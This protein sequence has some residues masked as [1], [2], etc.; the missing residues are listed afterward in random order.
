M[1]QEQ[2]LPEMDARQEDEESDYDGEMERTLS[3]PPLLPQIDS[4][5][6]IELPSRFGSQASKVSRKPVKVQPEDM[7][8]VPAIPRKSSRR[9]SSQDAAIAASDLAAAGFSKD[10]PVHDHC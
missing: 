8:P 3:T 6:G 1:E 2:E 4:V 10:T 5:G 7:P 9:T